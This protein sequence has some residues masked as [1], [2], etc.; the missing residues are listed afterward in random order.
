MKTKILIVGAGPSG[1][2][3]GTRLLGTSLILE[4]SQRVGGLCKSRKIAGTTF[5]IGGHSF[6]T[7]HQDVLEFV[8]ET[9]FAPLHKQIRDARVYF[10]GEIIPY[11]F[12]RHFDLIKDDRVVK[13][14]E[15]GL[16]R[17]RKDNNVPAPQNFLEAIKG[18]FGSG[19]LEHFLIPYNQKIW[20]RDLRTMSVNWVPER[21]SPPK[22]EQQVTFD[23]AKNRVALA[24]DTTVRYPA[25]G[26]FETIFQDIAKRAGKIEF[27]SEVTKVDL[28]H[29]ELTT[30]KGNTFCWSRMV[31]TGPIDK[32]VYATP[33]A[34][35]EIHQLTKELEK[36]SLC[37]TYIVVNKRLDNVPHRLYV[38]A[39][40]WPFHKIVFNNTSSPELQSEPHHGVMAE[41]SVSLDGTLNPNEIRDKFVA[42]LM[43]AKI[44]A[45]ADDIISVTSEI[46]EYAYPVPKI[47]CPEVV[48]KIQ[49]FY[50]RFGIYTLGRF[51]CW[52]YINSDGCIKDALTLADELALTDLPNSEVTTD[53]RRNTSP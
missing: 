30:T 3:L 9:A 41:S 27:N 2:T 31:W 40:E 45:S 1:L 18:K 51:G 4:S 11:P 47:G 13:E 44:L 26:G 34:P 23:K 7:P 16:R 29:R 8:E 46:V 33:E 15:E 10:D 32:L 48:E 38:H 49:E 22:G 17:I 42:F 36:L 19:I 28:R 39:P 35:E 53:D 24:N 20:R 14:C 37:L 52:R 50:R 21:I 5:D 6:H 25:T 43:E 12:Q